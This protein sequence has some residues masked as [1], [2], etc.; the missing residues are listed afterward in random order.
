MNERFVAVSAVTV[1]SEGQRSRSNVTKI[2][3]LLRFTV[4]RILTIIYMQPTSIS[5]WT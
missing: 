4:T 5:A 3:S 1:S 2:L